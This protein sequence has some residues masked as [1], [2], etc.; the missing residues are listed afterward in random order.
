MTGSAR[1]AGGCLLLLALLACTGEDPAR[2]AST[3]GCQKAPDYVADGATMFGVSLSSD[4]GTLAQALA[5]NR[6]RF[7]DLPVVRQFDPGIPPSGTWADRTEVFGHRSVI[8][9]FRAA[10][11]A[12]L[13]GEY[14]EEL[15]DAFESMPTEEPIFWSYIH[16]PEAEVEAGAF[17]LAEYRRAWRHIV[18]LAGS[19]CRG[20]L[21]PT[22]ILTGWTADPDSVRD[23]RDYYPGN[24][25]ISVLGWDPYNSATHTPRRYQSPA[26]IFGPVVGASRDAGKPWGVAETGS[27]L[28]AGDEGSGRAAWLR[29]VGQY[30]SDHQAAFVAYFQSTH[31]GAF[32]LDDPPSVAAYRSL[33][34]GS[35]RPDVD[36]VWTGSRPISVGSADV[37]VAVTHMDGGSPE[38]AGDPAVGAFRLPDFVDSS[39]PPRAAVVVTPAGSVDPLQPG[40]RDFSFGADIL[41]DDASSGSPVDNGDNLL[42][43]GLS[44]DPVLFKVELDGRRPACTVRGSA[45]EVIVRAPG[46]IAPDHWYHVE[47]LRHGESV[48]VEV[49]DVESGTVSQQRRE[50]AT[51]E[52][53]FDDP[54][55]PLSIGGKAARGGAL[56]SSATDQFN[57]MIA[58]PTLRLGE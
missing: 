55:V 25:Y 52:L 13:S 2:H 11:T 16:E 45:G 44:S 49:M 50:G 29:R 56:I 22:L 47:C 18:D 32:R 42:Q 4:D 33:V 51:G 15:L 58:H 36:V 28:V 26:S 7:G 37:T 54:S 20:N 30:L 14:D 40:T 24:G 43:R 48:S 27:E 38:P 5:T 31:D 1:L 41:L 8:T 17:T 23:W 3:S 53:L 39:T 19:L 35:R 6:M 10:P 34:A 9:S 57:G 21:F 12:V 46:P